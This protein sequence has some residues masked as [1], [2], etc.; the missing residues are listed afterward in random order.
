MIRLSYS[1]VKK[2]TGFDDVV[3]GNLIHRGLLPIRHDEFLLDGSHRHWFD[4]DD[5][6]YL[7][8]WPEEAEE[9]C[10]GRWMSIEA[11]QDRLSWAGDFAFKIWKRL[12]RQKLQKIR[13]MEKNYP[14][15]RVEV[16]YSVVDLENALAKNE[17]RL[18]RLKAF[19]ERNRGLGA[20]GELIYG[21]EE[22]ETVAEMPIED[23]L[24]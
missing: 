1:E 8:M 5:V 21:R 6:A 2:R 14:S 12:E 16:V 15:G 4:E 10:S 11:V 20:D 22:E 17:P 19:F 9:V 3:L 23:D 7:I 24:A 18:R 13:T